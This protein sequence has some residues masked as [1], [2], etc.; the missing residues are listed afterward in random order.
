M[1]SGKRSIRSTYTPRSTK[2]MKYDSS[3]NFTR[4]YYSASFDLFNFADTMFLKLINQRFTN[5]FLIVGIENDK[6][7][8]IMSLQEREEALK[9]CNFVRQILCPA[10]K[11]DYMFLKTFQIEYLC[12]TPDVCDN[13]AELHLGEGLVVLNPP[14]KITSN[15]L[16]AR[17]ISRRNQFLTRSLSQGYTRKQLGISLFKQLSLK[18]IS[19]T[20][21]TNTWAT[22]RFKLFNDFT[23]KGR[24]II[25]FIAR[26]FE[27]I[28]N[29]IKESL[30][31]NIDD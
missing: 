27:Y 23:R 21:I 29:K 11:V 19:F 7:N 10:P 26:K 31:G 13:Y 24:K 15:D 6:D 16:V 4:V 17:V 9:Q 28:E 3:I 25:K 12:S 2:K 30:V 20:T 14:V 18:L 8:Y 22:F 1:E 5:C